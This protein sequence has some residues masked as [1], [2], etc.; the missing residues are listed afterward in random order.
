MTFNVSLFLFWKDFRIQLENLSAYLL[1]CRENV[2]ES[3][4][5]M[6]WPREYLY[7]KIH[8]YSLSVSIV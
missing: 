6:L 5:K 2:M 3:L 1:T 7:E 8:L 4:K